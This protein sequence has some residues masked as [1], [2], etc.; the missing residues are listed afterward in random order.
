MPTL[1]TIPARFQQVGWALLPLRAFLAAVF[2]WA[3]IDKIVDRRFLDDH[4]PSGIR[5]T[6]VAVRPAS[7]IGGLL[8]P[9][10][11]HSLVFGLAICLAEIAVGLGLAL[12]LF[13]RLAALGGMVLSL[14]F[15]LTVSW[16]A[17]PWFTGAD[18]GYTFALMP[19][20]LAGA[21]GVY[22]LDAWLARVAIR[23]PGRGEDT[24]RRT[25]LGAG[26]AIGGLLVAGTSSLFRYSPGSQAKKAGSP[27]LVA[28]ADVPVG[29]AKQ[30]TDQRT[31]DPSWVLQL[32]SGTFTAFSAICPHQH[33][34][35]GF[36]SAA[37]GFACPCH[38]STF[39][40]AGKLIDGPA[41]RGLTEIAVSVVDGTV[42]QTD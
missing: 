20:V 29:G 18:L 30:V 27:D 9:V 38:Q 28:A 4:S 40:S 12:G 14:S 39:T 35:V 21:G 26:V 5:A 16:Q 34:T 8:G 2:L 22:S 32:T 1:P 31:G 6:L 37:D 15:F 36:V 24:T 10:Q 25:L 41:P 7:P 17:N 11:D 33:C 3:G 13:T 19:L 23:Y 42:Q